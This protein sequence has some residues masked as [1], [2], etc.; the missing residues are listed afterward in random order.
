MTCTV[1]GKNSNNLYGTDGLTGSY[2]DFCPECRRKA[3]E[4]KRRREREKR[5]RKEVGAETG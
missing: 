2:E 1:C 4:R 5:R 3:E